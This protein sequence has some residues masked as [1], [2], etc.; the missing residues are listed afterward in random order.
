MGVAARKRRRSLPGCLAVLVALAIV[1]GVFY[2]GVTKGVA[3]VSDQFGERRGLRRS[4]HRHGD[5]RGARGRQLGRDLPQPQGRR[6]WSPPSTPASSAAQANPESTEHPG[7]LLPGEEGDGVRRRHRAPGRPGEHRHRRRDHPRGAAG[8]RHGRHPG[9]EDRLLEGRLREGPGQA[10]AARA[11]PTTP[12]ATP[13]AT[14]SRRPTPSART[15]SRSTCC[16]TWSTAGSRRPTD[17][18][19]EAARRGARL[20]AGRADDRRQ[21]G[22]GRGPGRRHAQGRAGHLQ[23]AREPRRR[24]ARPGA[25][26]STPPS[27]TPRT[28]S[29]ARSRPRRTSS[30][31]RRTTPTRTPGLPPGPIEAPGDAA[32]AGGRQPGRRRLVLLRHRQPAR[33]AR[34]SSPRRYDEFLQYKQ[35]LRDYCENESEG[36]C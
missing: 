11:C 13:R 3:W 15:R 19:L 12:R 5:R 30:S 6:A 26:R 36:A 21:P 33:P 1:V 10:R 14:C 9:Q 23:P 4:R 28:T 24:P 7:R 25:S 27:T 29:S 2:F 31:T 17:A 22:R 20:H 34:P 35:E 18:D 8:R 16:A 32:I